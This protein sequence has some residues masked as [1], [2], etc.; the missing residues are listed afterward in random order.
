MLNNVA[1]CYLL[2]WNVSAIKG[3]RRKIDDRGKRRASKDDE[4]SNNGSDSET[5]FSEDDGEVKDTGKNRRKREEMGDGDEQS[6]SSTSSDEEGS[7]GLG[8]RKTAVQQGRSLGGEGGTTEEDEMEEGG[9]TKE[10]EYGRARIV[11][12]SDGSR[13]DVPSQL[14]VPVARL[15]VATVP[16]AVVHSR[17]STASEGQVS[18]LKSLRSQ[19]KSVGNIMDEV[20]YK[21]DVVRYCKDSVFF[22]VP[23]PREDTF[24]Y[25]DYREDMTAEEKYDPYGLISRMVLKKFG[26]RITDKEKWWKK[27]K[28][29]ALKAI[30]RKRNQTMENMQNSYKSK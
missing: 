16:V 13:R 18:S 12:R 14:R 28:P 7:Y 10:R 29:H 30:S 3:G 22:V 1:Q 4:S 15:P 26:E 23:F 27:M 25:S 6:V 8:K 9:G 19:E 11:P 21:K 5:G 17:V 24:R 20:A 2:F